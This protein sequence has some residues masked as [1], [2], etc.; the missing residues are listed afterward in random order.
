MIV[1]QTSRNASASVR[2]GFRIYGKPTRLEDVDR[3]VHH[4]PHYVDE[5][6]IDS[7]DFDAVMVLGA[8][9]PAEGADG[10]DQEDREADEDVQAVKAREAEERRRERAVAR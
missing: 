7:S 5:V 3:D 4:N 10:H 1:S 6:P 2:N 9:V 8:E